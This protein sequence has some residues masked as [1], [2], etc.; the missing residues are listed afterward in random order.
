M[1]SYALAIVVLSTFTHAYWNF[2]LKRA[3]GASIFIALSKVA[4]VVCFA[5]VF[6]WFLAR[7]YDS[8]FSGAG[9]IAVGAV[10]VL[11]NYSALARAYTVGDLSF[12]Y[13]V[14]RAGILL[15]L[16][17]LGFLV[18][19]ERL[20]MV[21]WMSVACIVVGI[22]FL[23]LPAFS[24]DALRLSITRLNGAS[25][26]YSLAAAFSA[27]VYTVWDKHAVQ[28]LAPFVYFY[29]YT[30]LGAVVY[31]VFVWQRTRS[32]EIARVWST[33][34]SS[35]VQVGIFNTVT[36]LLVLFALREG[37]SSYV[38][39]LRQLSIVWGALLGYFVLG[40][41]LSAPKRVG[42]ATLVCGCVLVAFAS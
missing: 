33:H 28:R 41:P 3:G 27:A 13:P 40:E 22:V 35:I 30:L 29:G 1:Q 2:L 21:G 18:F 39:A 23:Q 16:P 12:V 42:L 37:T 9:L 4:E 25:I 14:S 17:A 24:P 5:P 8:A 38:I 26:G 36:Y 11:F 31:M 10:L 19:R 32:S 6:L 34:R 7:S 15:F 20:T